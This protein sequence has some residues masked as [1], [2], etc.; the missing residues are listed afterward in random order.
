MGREEGYYPHFITLCNKVLEM[1]RVGPLKTNLDVALRGE[2]AKPNQFFHYAPMYLARDW[3]AKES[4]I[5]GPQD[6]ALIKPDF[7]VVHEDSESIRKY[8]EDQECTKSRTFDP[9]ET[10]TSEHLGPSPLPTYRIRLSD[11]LCCG[12]VKWDRATSHGPEQATAATIREESSG[13]E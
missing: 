13:G 11:V 9:S 6:L 2:D 4:R 8:K 7:I 3:E 10:C 1:V 12:E 5:G